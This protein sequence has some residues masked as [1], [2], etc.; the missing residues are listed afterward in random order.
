[1]TST[2]GDGILSVLGMLQSQ[3]N[4][5]DFCLLVQNWKSTN[6]PAGFTTTANPKTSPRVKDPELFY[7]ES[8]DT[9]L[10]TST[11]TGETQMPSQARPSQSVT[12]AQLDRPLEQQDKIDM[13]LFQMSNRIGRPLSVD[14][15]N[16]WHQDLFPYSVKAIEFALD[17][18]G[19]SA[20]VLPAFA[21]LLSLLRSWS[22]EHAQIEYCVHCDTGWVRGFKDKA[23]NDAVKRCECM[24]V[25]A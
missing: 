7:Q 16:Q 9:R 12:K 18:W 1:M 6:F 11:D 21:D 10:P 23:G 2:G 17:S 13:A 4:W 19:R 5:P 8:T 14:R 3:T 15:I 25:T 24:K 22:S 20:K